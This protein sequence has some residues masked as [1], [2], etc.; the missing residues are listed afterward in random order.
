MDILNLV[1]KYIR[2][3]GSDKMT[4]LPSADI[5]LQAVNM[6]QKRTG[7][8]RKLSDLA[9]VVIWTT[10]ESCISHTLLLSLNH[11]DSGSC[12]I[13][14][15]PGQTTEEHSHN[16][17]ELLYVAKGEMHQ[18]I[19]GEV[20]CFEEREFCLI[21]INV[22]HCEFYSAGE[23]LIVC[24][25]IDDVFF[26]K[27]IS[28]QISSEL[29]TTL[30]AM[31]NRKRSQYLYIRFTPKTSEKTE[32]IITLERIVEELM[33]SFPN[34]QHITVDYIERLLILLP[35]EYRMNI[36][37]SDQEEFHRAVVGDILDY[38]KAN[39]TTVSVQDIASVYHYNPDYINRLFVRLTGCTISSHIQKTR[40]NYAMEL[41]LRTDLSV[42]SISKRTGYQNISFFYRKFREEYQCTPASVRRK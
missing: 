20:F 28:Q 22:K 27:E 7:A 34:R 31:V 32:S 15:T 1:E 14:Y 36:R 19:A 3:S 26:V 24:L 16:H 39:Y 18:R 33:C 5:H 2:K 41:L 37:N 8:K 35:R 25:G 38:I 42:K 21:D 29:D 30:K 40:M 12:P 17:I 4:P 13:R 9:S 23:S 6:D 10:A 11:S